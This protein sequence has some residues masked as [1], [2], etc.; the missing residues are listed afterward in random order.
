V[1]ARDLDALL[2]EADATPV[3]G[4]DHGR[5]GPRLS[6]RPRPWDFS[7]IVAERARAARDHLD[8]GTGGGE[9]LAAL[10]HRAARTVATEAWPPNV[11]VAG[12]RLRQLGITVVAVEPAPDNVDA[13]AGGAPV[14][15]PFPS[16]SFDL[17]T[18][19]HESF[20][21]AEV[22]RVLAP[23]GAFLTQQ[24]GGDYGEFHDALG[25]PHPSRPERAWDLRLATSQVEAAGLRV[26]AGGEARE[27]VVFA[28]AG[29]L[30]WYLRAIPWVV[31]GFST[32][33]HRAALERVQRRIE[34]DGPLVVC[35]P[36]FW[37]AAANI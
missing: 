26:E 21:A 8:L 5:L 34:A 6:S 33:S 30:A 13:D 24:T 11:D 20:V 17:V 2:R 12:A 32:A 31:D 7:A 3:D 29:A 37:L 10:A 4:W 27:E 19:R 35:Q 9:W 25:L 14:R 18:S 36:T 15:L 23:G 16:R 28:D 1:S 22:A